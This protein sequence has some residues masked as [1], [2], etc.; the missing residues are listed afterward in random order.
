MNSF[1]EGASEDIRDIH[2]SKI[3]NEWFGES[4]EF[5]GIKMGLC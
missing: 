1:N 5:Q 2:D 3:W 4:V